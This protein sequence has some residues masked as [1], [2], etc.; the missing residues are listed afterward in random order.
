MEKI[1]KAY[2]EVQYAL[3]AVEDMDLSRDA[4]IDVLKDISAEATKLQKE[5]EA[6]RQTATKPINESLRTI[7]GWF[8]PILEACDTLKRRANARLV[9]ANKQRERAREEALGAI[10]GAGPEVTST[11]ILTAQAKPIDLPKGVG[12]ELI[13]V[14]ITDESMIPRKF[15]TPDTKA[16]KKAATEAHRK[17]EKFSVPG[18]T[19]KIKEAGT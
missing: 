2:S 13:V 17:G 12:R 7:N 4:N 10:A 18:V 8:K 5:M 11:A 19:I 1:T 3:Q 6:E 15:L 14:E 9:E 16:I